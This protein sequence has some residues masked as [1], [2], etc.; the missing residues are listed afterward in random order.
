[1]IARDGQDFQTLVAL[2]LS[3]LWAL[4]L[5]FGHWS[6]DVRFLD[7]AE[8][9]LTDLRLLARGERPAPDLVTIVA[10]DDDTV[11]KQGGY[12]LPRADLA[13]HRRC[14]RPPRAAR[15]R[16][17]PLAARSRP[18]PGRATQRWRWR[19]ANARRVIASAAVF[20]EATQ[21]LEAGEDGPLARLPRAEKFLLPLKHSPIMPPSAWST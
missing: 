6:G 4:A 3:A 18:R 7:R 15:R 16:G 10:I 21:L 11:A 13:A 12:P 1:M 19:S 14:D 5:G 20:P 8:G 17:R 2:L 9:A